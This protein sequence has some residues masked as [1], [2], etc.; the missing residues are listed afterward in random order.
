VSARPGPNGKRIY[1]M[2]GWKVI[3]EANRIFGYDGW[4]QKVI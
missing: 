1:Y 4:S 3:N 2:E